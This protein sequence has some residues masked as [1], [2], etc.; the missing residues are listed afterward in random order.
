MYS[1]RQILSLPVDLGKSSSMA[2][3]CEASSPGRKLGLQTVL[4]FTLH[5]ALFLLSF[6]KNIF[7][8]VLNVVVMD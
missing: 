2:Y 6:K 3:E 1:I 7:G 4:K 5:G 8:L